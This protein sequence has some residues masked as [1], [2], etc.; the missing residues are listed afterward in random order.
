MFPTRLLV[1]QHQYFSVPTT[2]ADSTQANP[3]SPFFGLF[4]A[5]ATAV[6]AALFASAYDANPL[7][8]AVL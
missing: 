3:D 5:T 4:S 6:I 7:S 1:P 2:Q 8:K